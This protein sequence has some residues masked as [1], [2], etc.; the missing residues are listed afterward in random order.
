VES[1]CCPDLQTGRDPVDDARGAPPSRL[2][3]IQTLRS[4]T[5]DST[6]A[7]S[8]RSSPMKMSPIALKWP[9]VRPPE[10][11]EILSSV[12]VTYDA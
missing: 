3:L 7:R 8:S 5:A 10:I 2:R 1:T 4:A 9:I 6:S 11:F 12:A